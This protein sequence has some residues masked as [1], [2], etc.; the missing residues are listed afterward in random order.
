MRQNFGR[1]K[2]GTRE[3]RTTSEKITAVTTDSTSITY[4]RLLTWRPDEEQ[5]KPL[6]FVGSKQD[7]R[8]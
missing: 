5:N 8:I 7:L 3:T 6:G 4:A 2:A 1:G